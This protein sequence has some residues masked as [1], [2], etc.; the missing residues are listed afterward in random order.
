[1]LISPQLFWHPRE[2]KYFVNILSSCDHV[3]RC[4]KSR[5][6]DWEW[7]G[8]LRKV[9]L[10]SYR[11]DVRERPFTTVLSIL[12]PN[13]PLPHET[14]HLSSQ[15][16]RPNPSPPQKYHNSS[17]RTTPS[18]S[19]PP[20]HTLRSKWMRPN[21][22]NLSTVNV[23]NIFFDVNGSHRNWKV[24]DLTDKLPQILSLKWNWIMSKTDAANY[25]LMSVNFSSAQSFLQLVS[26][27][28]CN[29]IPSTASFTA[30]FYW[31]L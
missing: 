28:W 10:G 8:S 30:A 27:K 21:I 16:H 25:W 29:A 2:R 3:W 22:I 4:S 23:L 19:I 31:I 13:H 1:M 24:G 15:L 18:P 11:V 7:F 14:H 17:F 20:P 12:Y 6:F 5:K 26:A 9:F